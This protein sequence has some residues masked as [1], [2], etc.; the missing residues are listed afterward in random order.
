VEEFHRLYEARYGYSMPGR[1]VVVGSALVEAV[2][3]VEKPSLRLPGGGGGRRAGEPVRGYRD[4]FIDGGWVRAEVVDWTLL[5]P[6]DT[7]EWPVVV[8]A[9]DTTL[10]VPRGLR[11]VVDEYGFIRLRR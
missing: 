8:E 2:G 1:P 3:L 6:G 5:S 11:G 10:L 7:L 4:V 9:P